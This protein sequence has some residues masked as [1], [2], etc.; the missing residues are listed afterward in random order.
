MIVSILLEERVFPPKEELKEKAYVKSF[1][2]YEKMY[3][4]SVGKGEIFLVRSS[5]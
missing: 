2:E 4:E 1:S 3:K 5:S